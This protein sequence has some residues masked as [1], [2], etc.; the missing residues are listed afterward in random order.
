MRI[1]EKLSCGNLYKITAAFLC[2]VYKTK[3]NKGEEKMKSKK[4]LSLILSVLLFLTVIPDITLAKTETKVYI[5]VSKRGVIASDN[6]GNPMANREVTVE[7]L[8]SDGT[9]TYD[10]ALVAAHK[11]YNQEDG[12]TTAESYGYTSVTKLWGIDAYN[13]LF[14]KNNTGISGVGTEAIKNGDNLVASIN[15]DDLYYADWYSFFN[16]LEKEVKINEE[17]SLTLKGHLGMAYSPED[18]QDTALSG[19]S[20]GLWNEGSFSQINGKVTNEMGSVTLAFDKA[21]TYYVTADGMIDDEVTVDWTTYATETK[22]CP[23]IAPVCVVTVSDEEF[24]PNAM[25]DEDAVDAV[26]KEFS[27]YNKMAS[28]LVFPLEYNDT[29]YTNVISYIKDWAKKETGRD[30]TVSYDTYIYT[31]N[32]TEWNSGS[33][34]SSS[35]DGLDNESNIFQGYFTNNANKTMN[36]LKD[37][38]FTVGKKT[39]EKVD[40]LYLSIKSL[41][42][43]PEEIVAYVKANIPFSRIANGNEDEDH[44]IQKLGEGT[45]AVLPNT[46]GLY[47]TTSVTIDWSCN[48][49][50]GKTDA[51]SVNKNRQVT[52]VRPNVGEEN[53]VFDLTATIKSKADTSVTDTKTF[54]LTVPDFEAVLVPIKVTAGAS[55]SLIDSYYGTSSA[56]SSKYIL[57]KEEAQDG[58]DIYECQLHTNATGGAQSFKYTVSKEGYIT[59]SGTISVTGNGMDD[60][61]IDLTA[62][63]EDD[64]KLLELKS[65]APE[66]NIEL[67]EDETEYSI[68]AYGVQSI[69]LAAT[70]KIPEA[71]AK[72][73]SYYSSVANANKGTLTTSGKVIS[74]SGVLCYLPDAV[75]TSVIKITVTAP[76]GSTQINKTRTYTVNVNKKKSSLPLTAL[77]VTAYSSSKG[78]KNNISVGERIPAEEVITPTFVAGGNESPYTYT[79]NFWRDQITVKPT[80][81]DCVITIN[82]VL[83][84]SGSESTKIPL[85]IGDNIVTV[86]V[87]K[88]SITENYVLNI[89]RK[90][91]FY[92]SNVTL[93]E[94][95]LVTELKG[96]GGDW[97]GSCNFDYSAKTVHIAYHTNLSEEEEKNVIIDVVISGKTY[98]GHAGESIE[99]PVGEAT[100]IMPTVWAYYES[101][102]GVREGHKF[103]ISLKRKAADAPSAVESYLPAPGQFVNISSYQEP[104]KTLNGSS[105]ITLG[106]FGGNIVY[107]Y[108]EPIKNSPNNRYGIDFIVYG[109]CFTN[110]DG[111][112]SSGA[113]EPASVMVS[114]D[115]ISWYELAGS[116]YY[117]EYARHNLT[118]TYINSDTTFTEATDTSW[119]DSDGETGVLPKNEYHK[120]AYY[121]NPEYY[122]AFQKGIGKNTTYTEN[123]VSFTG[124]M[125]DSGFYPFGYADSHSENATCGNDAVNPYTASHAYNYNGDGFDISWAVDEVGDPVYLDEIS[126]IKIYNPVLSYSEM[127]GEK[128]P[129]IK[130]VLRTSANSSEVGKS[131]GLISLNVNGNNIN[132]SESTY[133]YTVDGENGSV[134]KITP[135]TENPDANIYVS[136]KRVKSGETASITA[137][138]KTRI[139][140]QEGDCEP[141][142]YIINFTNVTEMDSNADLT[143]VTLTPGDVTNT[144]ENGSLSFD[145][146]NGVASIRFIPQTANKKAKISVSGGSLDEE[147]LLESSEQSKVLSLNVGVNEFIFKVS[148]VNGKKENTY[149]VTVTREKGSSGATYDDNTILVKFSLT[150][151]KLHYDKARNEYTGNH[152]NPIWIS[153]TAVTVPKGSTVKYLTEMMLNNAGIDYVTDGVY[154]SEING[155]GE[156]DNGTDSGWLYRKNGE[157]ANV[158]Y[159]DC[160]L[161]SGDVIKWFYTDDYTKETGYEGGWDSVNSRSG[162]ATVEKTEVVSTQDAG[163]IDEDI[164]INQDAVSVDS[165]ASEVY[166]DVLADSWYEKSVS[167]VTQRN[168]FK[169]VSETDFAPESKMTR[170]MLVTVLFR[171]EN[172]DNI[173][174]E[175]SF[176]DVDK[177]EWYADAIAWAAKYG[178][179]SG[180]SETEFAPNESITRE[181]MAVIVYRYAALKGYNTQL[182]SNLSDFSDGEEISAY[183]IDALKWANGEEIIMGV[184]DTSIS[185]KSTATRAQFAAILMRFCENI[186]SVQ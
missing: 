109:N 152:T 55:I 40:K 146:D 153:K 27:A 132:L 10:E 181:Q 31:T 91:E 172:P 17:F 58:Y 165:R 26:Y 116:E 143:S 73:T 97:T 1:T 131:S 166:R 118:L 183:A 72:I 74:S 145:V 70:T 144:A 133:T 130:T 30:V 68:D 182:K 48:N 32:Y 139:I 3:E 155:I 52:I 135:V 78:T 107:K 170:A 75:S 20:I 53:A 77:T 28:G 138:D 169:G 184:S 54:H 137:V 71:T 63:T 106:A 141:V 19:I 51:M 103:I 94:G 90:A 117:S 164:N 57:K 18:L 159:S 80:A 84:N 110:S 69:K 140:V 79:V 5:T 83:V 128:S 34:V 160:V 171:L 95:E 85:N 127:T 173:E 23:I 92:I 42:R 151:D 39:S 60:T 21:G 134:F 176:L 125:I 179:V 99:I 126:Y 150:G 59:K 129:E 4:I 163:N 122:N 148:S 64:T 38:T 167:Y 119:T 62:S 2:Y 113:A 149:T 8:D 61:V 185:P 123:T 82:G 124:T 25:S 104:L 15:K 112:T 157:I 16:V 41:E 36:Y 76:D 180:I 102:D 66:I 11:M 96:D 88:N 35:Y 174:T 46:T 142:I 45:S 37:L 161:S 108:D 162:T 177:S 65:I 86:S 156:F 29:T 56:V 98:S 49:I 105:F 154:I 101:A 12:Y 147:I 121:P 158:G 13:T 115:G 47:N 111:S 136:N 9:L 114:K 178:V 50:S 100:S 175:Y 44:I 22:P 186:I 168:L 14:F 67:Q 120:Q 6:D 93:D 24:D 81:K 43:T 33:P 89:R 87:K 7:D